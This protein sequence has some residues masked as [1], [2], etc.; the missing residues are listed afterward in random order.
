MDVARAAA[1]H[2]RNA[3]EAAHPLLPAHASCT[4]AN[5]CLAE[6]HACHVGIHPKHLQRRCGQVAQGHTLAAPYHTGCSRV[7]RAQ[8]RHVCA[9][10]E[11]TWPLNSSSSTPLRWLRMKSSP[12]KT[13]TSRAASRPADAAAAAACAVAASTL[14]LLA[15]GRWAQRRCRQAR[16]PCG[17]GA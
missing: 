3:T 9:P 13:A 10:A 11:R 2:R 14:L 7:A 1:P 6:V 17:A 12:P 15:A 8:A 16:V 4:P 5:A